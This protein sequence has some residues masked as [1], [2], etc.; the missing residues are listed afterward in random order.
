MA[1]RLYEL[2]RSSDR[3]PDQLYQLLHDEEHVGCLQKLP[4]E[5]LDQLI[6]Y[7]NDVGFPLISAECH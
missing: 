2:N 5:E 1:L 7:L 3:F 4:K 6:N